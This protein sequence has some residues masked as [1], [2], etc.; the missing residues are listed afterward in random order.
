MVVGSG[1]VVVG[2]GVV[3]VVVVGFCVVGFGVV[4]FG[5]GGWGVGVG[6][7]GVVA[8]STGSLHTGEM[9]LVRLSTWPCA[10]LTELY[11]SY[12]MG[13]LTATQ[14]VVYSFNIVA[15]KK[16]YN[17]VFKESVIM[18]KYII[19]QLPG[20]VKINTSIG[21]PEH[22]MTLWYSWSLPDDT[23]FGLVFIRSVG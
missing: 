7:W 15:L 22:H 23:E 8:G 12:T 9:L 3:V 14:N 16:K 18:V 2:L 13:E 1:V 4:G 6:G 21:V 20:F 19:L 10:S 5:V 11:A 17:T